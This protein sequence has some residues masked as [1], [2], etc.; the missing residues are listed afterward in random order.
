MPCLAACSSP[1]VACRPTSR[2]SGR[3]QRQRP[4]SP[5][6]SCG[7]PLNSGSVS[8]HSDILASSTFFSLFAAAAASS[9]L[10]RSLRSTPLRIPGAGV[11]ACTRSDVLRSASVPSAAPSAG[12]RPRLRLA[13]PLGRRG[14]SLFGTV[15]MQANQSFE[16]TRSAAASGC[17][18]QQLWRAA[19]L[20]I[21]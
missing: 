1:L 6:S 11:G 18:G 4:A 20:Q 19:Q 8:V 2:S 21:R 16:R 17:A 10:A 9:L 3:V 5:G 14:V 7:A 12:R 15:R 13:A